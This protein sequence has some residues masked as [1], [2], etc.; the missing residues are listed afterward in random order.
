MKKDEA[1]ARQSGRPA[2]IVNP[3]EQEAIAVLT[4]EA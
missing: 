2:M 3:E 1:S 4:R